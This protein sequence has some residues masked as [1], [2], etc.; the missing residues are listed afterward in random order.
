MRRILLIT[1]FILLFYCI[2]AQTSISGIVKD[3][4]TKSVLPFVNVFL[5]SAK[6]SAFISGTVTNEEADS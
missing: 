6:D 5:K 3:K 1:Q 2:N 4:K